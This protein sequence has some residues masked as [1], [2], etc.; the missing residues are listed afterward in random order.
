MKFYFLISLWLFNISWVSAQEEMSID[1]LYTP[2]VGSTWL[3]DTT[4][5]NG[6]TF[7]QEKTFEFGLG[8]KLVHTK[9]YGT[10]DMATGAYG[11]RNEGIH[12]LEGGSS[13]P[14]FWE[15]DV[16]GG[17]TEGEIISRGDTIAYN[18]TYSV[19]GEEVTMQDLLIKQDEDTYTYIIRSL[20]AGKIKKVFLE[21]KMIRKEEEEE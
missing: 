17:V 7:R 20:Q 16:F 15:F 18:Y 1:S 14:H 12:M 19:S 8:K 2:F 3:I 4:W 6:V 9:T 5:A 11:L 10:V 13:K 21:T